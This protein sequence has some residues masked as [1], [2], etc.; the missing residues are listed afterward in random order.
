MK[1]R[2]L[3]ILHLLLTCL[4]SCDT[5]MARAA[6]GRLYSADKMSSTSILC[7]TQDAYGFIW[8]GTDYGLNRFDGYQFDKYFHDTGDSTS[9]LSNEI[10][11]FFVDSRQQLWIGC[12]KGLMRYCYENNTFLRYAFPDGLQPRVISI[13]ENDRGEI[14]IGTSGYGLFVLAKGANT[15]VRSDRYKC[16]EDNNFVNALFVD[17]NQNLWCSDTESNL[18][19][20]VTGKTGDKGTGQ[21]NVMSGQVAS[22]SDSSQ[23]AQGQNSQGD[24][25]QETQ[26]KAAQSKT[27][28]GALA[29][30]TVRCDTLL[31]H[32]AYGPVVS[33]L[34]QDLRGFYM[35][36]MYGIL[37]YD[38]MR[39]TVIQT[40]HDLSVL[41]GNISIRDASF[42]QDGNLYL[43]TSG[44]GLMTIPKG[45]RTL[46]KANNIYSVYDLATANVNKVY[47]DRSGNLWVSCYKR[48][49]LQVYKSKSTFSTW[50]I[51]VQ[52]HITGSGV[53]SVAPAAD[54]GVYCVMQKSGI[55]H[56]DR[57]GKMTGMLKSPESPN[58]LYRD[59]KGRYW[60]GTE[61]FLYEYFPETGN[62]RRVCAAEGLAVACI[63]GDGEDHIFFGCDGKG[64]YIYNTRN[65]QLQSYTT[66]DD[67]KVN[68]RLCNNWIR[69]LYYDS[70]RLLWIATVN[71]LCCLNP[72]TRD[73]RTLGWNSQ[74]EGVKCYSL[75]EQPDGSM[76]IGTENGLYKYE[77]ET[78]RFGIYPSSGALRE[79]SIYSIALDGKSDIWMSLPNGILYLN[80]ESGETSHYVNG[81]GLEMSEY[82]VGGQ[83]VTH[84]GRILFGNN[85]GVTSFYPRSVFS[86]SEKVEKPCLSRFSVNGK[87]R[88]CRSKSFHIYNH[89]DM[90]QIG[91][92][93]LD[94]QR[95][96]NTT[97]VYRLNADDEWKEQA[98]G[99]NTLSFNE[100]APGY[101][102]VEVKTRIGNSL[103][104]QACT[105]SIWVASPWYL[106]YWAWN[107]YFF[108]F[109]ALIALCIYFYH[110]HEQRK[111]EAEKQKF[112]FNTTNEF[113]TPLSM[114]IE[115]LTKIKE[116]TDKEGVYIDREAIAKNWQIITENTEKLVDQFNQMAEKTRMDSGKEKMHLV[117][118]PGSIKDIEVKGNDEML[119]ER[120]VKSVNAHLTDPDFDVQVLVDEIGLSRS[121]LHRKMRALTGLATADFIRTVRLQQAERLIREDKINI[122]QIAL[123]VGFSNQS[124]FS[125]VFRRYYGKSPKQFAAEVQR[126]KNGNSAETQAATMAKINAVLTDKVNQDADEDSRFGYPEGF[127]R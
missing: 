20:Y 32:S 85:D 24:S 52:D 15:A 2:S 28:F 6:E 12:R 115:P 70:R 104:G 38:T 64:L 18:I 61:K 123:T 97:Y 75:A 81:D 11:A 42:D 88:D 83:I 27:D 23:D 78:D 79:K 117:F 122:T 68:G 49:L 89:N 94:Y 44:C 105:F 95:Q 25:S 108:L 9:I 17:N 127:K 72:A 3:T 126:E 46:Q 91:F 66:E 71:G 4:L 100:L 124:H 37:Y 47:E 8:T 62:Y 29:P 69:G 112:L 74:F 10:T 22:D 21:S 40:D 114:I 110:R 63:S 1:Y 31:Y 87:Y 43:G 19:R 45:K 35:V 118:K 107:L 109:M 53:I 102:D 36:C 113:H 80:A 101:Y 84:D 82:I 26:G 77:R 41:D 48:G 106:S 73:F 56:F 39:D 59:N 54:G 121:Q 65:S 93:T 50:R 7:V 92:S 103:S 76:L 13:V 86:S 119:L 98:K 34:K 60:L 96:D 30:D 51:S 57:N 58:A 99:I 116:I 90:V 120:I 55:C 67:P 14:V 125:T 111:L 16:K 33:F 5:L